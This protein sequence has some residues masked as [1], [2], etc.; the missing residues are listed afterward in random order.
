MAEKTFAR[1][2]KILADA[3]ECCRTNLQADSTGRLFLSYRT[4]PAQGLDDA[5]HHGGEIG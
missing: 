5:R 1:D 3:C 2:R 4:V